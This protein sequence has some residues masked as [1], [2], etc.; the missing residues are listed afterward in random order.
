MESTLKEHANTM[1][2]TP[3]PAGTPK[4][5]GGKK[6]KKKF[7]WQKDEEQTATVVPI[8]KPGKSSPKANQL[9]G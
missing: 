8:R 5:K 6:K 9:P 7:F 1:A 3:K 4:D 2:R